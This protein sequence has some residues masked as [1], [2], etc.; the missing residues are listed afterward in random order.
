MPGDLLVD[1]LVEVRT[2]CIEVVLDAI[3]GTG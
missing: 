1:Q 3:S 2:H